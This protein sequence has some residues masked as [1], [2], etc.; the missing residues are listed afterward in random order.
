MKTARVQLIRQQRSDADRYKKWITTRDKEI[1]ILKEKG[2]KAQ[3]EMNRMNRMHE[4][5]QAVLKRKV[6]EAKA[7][8]KRLQDAMDRNRKIQAMRTSNKIADKSEIVQTYIDHELQVLM[9]TIDAN[10]AMKSLMNDRGLLTERLM[11]LKS[12]V[13]KNEGIDH[14]IK[15]LEEDLEMRNAQI[16]DIRQK[17]AQTDREAKMKSIPDNFHTVAELKI[18]MSYVLAALMDARE[19]FTNAK[20]KAEDIKV[21]YESSEERIEHLTE[22]FAK[23]RDEFLALKSQIEDDFETKLNFMCQLNNGKATNLKE[24]SKEDGSGSVYVSMAKQL[25]EVV[26]KNKKLIED[27]EALAKELERVSKKGGDATKRKVRNETFD[28]H[29]EEFDSDDSEFDINDSFQDPDW[30]KT[31]A[32]RQRFLKRTTSHLLKE[33]ITN[34]MDGTGMLANISETSDTSSRKRSS[35]SSV[36]CNCKGS[37]ATKQC[38]CKKNGNFCTST[39]CK[40]SEACVNRPDESDESQGQ[41]NAEKNDEEGSPISKQLKSAQTIVNFKKL[42]IKLF[43]ISFQDGFQQ[44]HHALLSIQLKETQAFVASV[45]QS[46]FS[47]LI[48]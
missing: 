30:V 32:Q 28:M 41:E 48:P 42:F 8:N 10:I 45:N 15:Q 29:D 40:C 47:C 35:N 19:D 6:I 1:N 43:F 37:C 33:S 24:D 34:R 38:G 23:E 27:N 4:N 12:A 13:N 5:K 17:V 26:E 11:N 21:A 9:S 22:D 14:E 46:T 16:I 2:K 36:K 18:A 25:C 3:N 7:V 31:P 39:A 20:V 44:H